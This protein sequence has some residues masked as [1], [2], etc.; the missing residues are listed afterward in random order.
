MAKKD[1]AGE[2]YLDIVLRGLLHCAGNG[3]GCDIAIDSGSP[4]LVV[5]MKQ[6]VVAKR[7]HLCLQYEMLCSCF[8]GCSI[9][10]PGFMDDE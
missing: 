5:E 10:L 6:A 1:E 2:L 4:L 8:V 3:E 7:S 9:T